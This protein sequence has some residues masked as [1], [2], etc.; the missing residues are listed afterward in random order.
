M[1]PGS[2]HL[3]LLAAC[4]ALLPLASPAAVPGA[5]SHPRRTPL[6]PVDPRIIPL[7][8]Q[9]HL[10]DICISAAR[11][12]AHEYPV[13]DPTNLFNIL[14]RALIDRIKIDT[15]RTSAMTKT[16][17]LDKM[18]NVGINNCL[19]S[20]EDAMEY[21]GEGIEAFITRDIR[22]FVTI[23]SQVIGAFSGCN[24]EFMD[25]PNPLEAQND[26]LINMAGNCIRI[27]KMTF[28]E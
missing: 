6:P 21:T 13:I 1:R 16:Q 11:S 20:Y 9:T 15:A 24:D 18:V 2:A 14:A 4:F 3:L 5:G 10:P 25:V 22:T 27:G 8:N 17:K 12:Y 19:K 7:C 23:F 26:R 28:K